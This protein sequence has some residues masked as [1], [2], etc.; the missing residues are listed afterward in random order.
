M[1]FWPPLAFII[2]GPQT[3]VQLN[4]GIIAGIA[5][6]AVAVTIMAVAFIALAWRHGKFSLFLQVR[7][8]CLYQ[9]YYVLITLLFV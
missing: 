2:L 4:G 8:G 6:A 1:F 5:I 3:G 7:G 9:L